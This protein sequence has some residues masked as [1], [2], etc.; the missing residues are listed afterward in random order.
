MDR[1]TEHRRTSLLD[2]CVA[3]WRN[4]FLGRVAGYARLTLL[5]YSSSASALS[6]PSFTCRVTVS[7]LFR[8]P[9]SSSAARGAR[10]NRSQVST[11]IDLVFQIPKLYTLFAPC[12][13]TETFGRPPHLRVCSTRLCPRQLC[14]ATTA[15]SSQVVLIM[16]D[17]LSIGS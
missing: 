1:Q 7:Y 16:R 12:D 3:S 15:A 9:P 5:A 13:C 10:I 4:V 6:F 14:L 11:S 17:L 2:V 8:S